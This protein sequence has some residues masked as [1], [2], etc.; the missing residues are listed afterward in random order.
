MAGKAR[1]RQK[2]SQSSL[3]NIYDQNECTVAVIQSFL[4]VIMLATNHKRIALKIPHKV[5]LYHVPG[6]HHANN[7]KYARDT[8]QYFRGK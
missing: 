4:L 2:R 3:P 7:R 6:R 8:E 5:V 1:I